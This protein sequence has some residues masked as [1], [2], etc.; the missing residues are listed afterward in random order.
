MY[1]KKKEI[2]KEKTKETISQFLKLHISGMFEVISLKFGMWTTDGGGHV[3]S[4]NV[5]FCKGNMELRMHENCI[6]FLPVNT[7]TIACRLLEAHNTLPC[8]LMNMNV[9]IVLIV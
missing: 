3:H 2:K 9:V 1:E 7:L 8:V 4:K 6:F 5:S